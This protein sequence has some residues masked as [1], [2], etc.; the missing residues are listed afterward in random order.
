LKT[1][2]I[3]T[4]LVIGLS[5]SR[6]AWTPLVYGIDCIS[7]QPILQGRHMFFNQVCS[8][9]S[10]HQGCDLWPCFRASIPPKHP[11]IQYIYSR[12]QTAKS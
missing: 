9:P 11:T 10:I 4:L 12:L 6:A 2:H 1:K 5:G 3:L 7:S 8:S